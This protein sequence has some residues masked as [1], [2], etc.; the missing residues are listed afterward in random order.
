VLILLTRFLNDLKNY[1]LAW[2][3]EM[4]HLDLLLLSR[5]QFTLTIG[6]HIIFPVLTIGLSIF[7]V[8]MEALW[9]RSGKIVFYHQARFWGNLFVLNFTIG[10]VTGIVM[11]FQFGTNWAIFSR[12]AGAYFGNILGYEAA[13]AFA[14]ESASLGLMA[15]GWGRIPKGIH[16]AATFIVAFAATL[17]AF[18][19]MNANSWM[20]MPTGVVIH[21]G[22]LEVESYVKAIFNPF[23]I[24]SFIHKWLA[25][26]QISLLV[27]GGLSAWYILKNRYT[28][29]FLTSFKVALIAGLI[30]APLQI[31][32][33]DSSARLVYSLLP[34][35]GSA[36]ESHWTTNETGKAAAWSIVAWPDKKNE[37]NLFSIQI[38]YMLSLLATHSLHGKVI[39]MKDIPSDE[40]PPIVLPFFAFRIMVT[41]GMVFFLLAIVTM[42]AWKKRLLTEDSIVRQ[43]WLLRAW[44][45]SLPLGYIAM[46]AG[47]IVR[48]VGRQP[49]SIYK[50]LRTSE[51]LSILGHGAVFGSLIVYTLLYT[52]LFFSFILFLIKFL[53]KGP[54]LKGESPDTISGNRVNT[55][56]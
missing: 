36:M 48:E 1:N 45:S 44:L 26:I 8:I 23:A 43:R 5:I 15:L 24:V 4:H 40:R 38:P 41:L 49:W 18:W 7:L 55:S 28:P 30:T 13:L 46:E 12:F 42:F 27:I 50:L 35:K 54:D 3:L 19:I 53:K 56:Y 2:Y 25:C 39:G 21:N 34:A 29:F 20:Q 10:V 47:W 32:S 9:I 11:E 31:L 33:G 52:F 22:R 14:A 37:R 16:F 51:S 6:F 17:S